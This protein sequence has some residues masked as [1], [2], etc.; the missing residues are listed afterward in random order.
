MKTDE[1]FKECERRRRIKAVEVQ[2]ELKGMLDSQRTL[3]YAPGTYFS[4]VDSQMACDLGWKQGCLVC[5]VRVTVSQPS[6]QHVGDPLM[7][8]FDFVFTD[9]HPYREYTLANALN[10]ARML[11][12]PLLDSS[13][14]PIPTLADAYEIVDRHHKKMDHVWLTGHAAKEV[15]L[16]AMGATIDEVHDAAYPADRANTRPVP[17]LRFRRCRHAH[18]G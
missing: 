9:R 6:R 16:L 17:R 15:I 13:E 8:F 3:Q 12:S 2:A 1:L 5:G 14:Q 4:V 11:N 7:A 10:L 18:E